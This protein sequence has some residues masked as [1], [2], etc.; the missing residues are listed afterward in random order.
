MAAEAAE[1]D[2]FTSIGLGGA[3]GAAESDQYN[4]PGPRIPASALLPI[5]L[6]RKRARF[7]PTPRL[8]PKVRPR[9]EVNDAAS[10]LDAMVFAGYAG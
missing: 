10:L 1:R 2:R 9:R 4:R 5:R 3:A 8:E 7:K 6:N